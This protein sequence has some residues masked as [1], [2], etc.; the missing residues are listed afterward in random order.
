MCR[1]R[2]V[3]TPSSSPG[4]SGRGRRPHPPVSSGVCYLY[5][6]RWRPGLLWAA[7]ALLCTALPAVL[8][9]RCRLACGTGSTLPS[10]TPSLRS[11]FLGVL[12]VA[13]GSD[14]WSGALALRLC[15]QLGSRLSSGCGVAP[16]G[17]P[18]WRQRPPWPCCSQHGTADAPFAARP[19]QA[20]GGGRRVQAWVLFVGR[21]VRSG[22]RPRRSDSR[23]PRPFRSPCQA[24]SA[25]RGAGRH[26]GPPLVVA[27]RAVLRRGARGGWLYFTV[28]PPARPTRCSHSGFPQEH[29]SVGG[30]LQR[31]TLLGF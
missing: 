16:C 17:A 6:I 26:T 2:R 19:R 23:W 9:S 12:A 5:F 13:V 24:E 11:A 20:R 1:M 18:P 14:G 22:E 21:H 10:P 15:Q 28:V 27:V 8:P 31:G 29:P 4:L 3:G 30:G 7:S 25:Q